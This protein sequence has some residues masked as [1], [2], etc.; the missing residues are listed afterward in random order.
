MTKKYPAKILLFGEYAVLQ[1]GE[2]LAIPYHENHAWWTSSNQAIDHQI[3]NSILYDLVAFCKQHQELNDCLDFDAL[4]QA[5]ESHTIATDIPIGYGL[6][7]SGSV[8]AAIYDQYAQNKETD[9]IRLKHL[10]GRM[11]DFFHQKSSGLDPLVCYLDTA[12]HISGDGL[13]TM[14]C[15]NAMEIELFDTEINRSTSHLVDVFQERMKDQEYAQVILNILLPLNQKCI[16]AW[17]AND[18]ATLLPLLKKLSSLQL[19]YFNFAI[20][21]HIQHEWHELLREG[22]RILKLCGAGGGGYMLQFDVA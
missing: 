10:L 9:I 13:H 18:V 22:K 15:K 7:S 5:L 1:G 8:V 6:G 19:E 14:H 20:P 2:G 21:T 12:V 4:M 3:P 16:A 17:L 11:E